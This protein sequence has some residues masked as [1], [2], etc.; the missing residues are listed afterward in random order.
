MTSL[1]FEN[2]G[3][4]DSGYGFINEEAASRPD[5]RSI[6]SICLNNPILYCSNSRCRAESQDH[7][8]E[9]QGLLLS[10]GAGV[11]ACMHGWG[12]HFAICFKN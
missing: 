6:S 9:T 11:C 4:W 3:K 12:F 8:P 7:H 1:V 5:L 2:Q 10:G